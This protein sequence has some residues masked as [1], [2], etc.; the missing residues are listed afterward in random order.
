MAQ[1]NG[2]LTLS[3]SGTFI[4]GPVESL[5]MERVKETAPAESVGGTI[6]NGQEAKSEI[7]VNKS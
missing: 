4:P 7:P 1:L 5:G 3:K 6:A 2:R